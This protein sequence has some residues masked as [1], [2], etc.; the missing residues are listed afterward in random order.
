VR[1]R[2]VDVQ[3]QDGRGTQKGLTGSNVVVGC[4]PRRPRLVN[5]TVSLPGTMACKGVER[6]ILPHRRRRRRQQS[7]ASGVRPGHLSPLRGRRKPP[8]LRLEHWQSCRPPT[9]GDENEQKTRRR[10]RRKMPFRSKRAGGDEGKQQKLGRPLRVLTAAAATH[11]GMDW[12]LELDQRR[13]T[14]GREE[15][16]KK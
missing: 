12:L 4:R 1:G 14:K 7:V 6:G 16:H 2:G 11:M 10:S 9:A 3:T 15:L 13:I 5:G 8:T